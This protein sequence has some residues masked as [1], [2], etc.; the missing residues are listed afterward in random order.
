MRMTDRIYILLTASEQRK[1]FDE[2]MKEVYCQQN[3]DPVSHSH[4][5]TELKWGKI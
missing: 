5:A 1:R 2:L 4:M 3:V